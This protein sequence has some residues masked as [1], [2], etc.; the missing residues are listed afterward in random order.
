MVGWRRGCV[1][2]RPIGARSFFG[3]LIAVALPVGTGVSQAQ[4][5]RIGAWRAYAV[6]GPPR[7]QER[8]QYVSFSGHHGLQEDWL[9]N[10]SDIKKYVEEDASLLSQFQLRVVNL[11]LPLPGVLGTPLGKRIDDLVLY[12]LT[13]AGYNVASRANSHALDFGSEGLRY[14]DEKLENLNIRI[15]G[16]RKSPVFHWQVGK[17]RID[18]CAVARDL[19]QPDPDHLILTADT[20]DLALLKKE[21]EGADFRIAFAILGSASRYPSPHE[22]TQVRRLLDAGFDLVVCTGSHFIKGFLLEQGRPVAY[23]IGDHLHSLQ[24][25]LIDTEPL[26]M[27][28]VV[29]FADGQLA[30]I[31]VVPFHNDVRRG[32]LG[33]L[34]EAAFGEFVKTF[35]ERSVSDDAKYFSDE[36]VFQMMMRA[37]GNMNR[38][39]L[40]KLLRPRYFIYGAR[41]IIRQRPEW[42]V[43][44]GA[45]LVI[46]AVVLHRRRSSRRSTGDTGNA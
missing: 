1:R 9:P 2:A 30:Q 35:R 16:E 46:V 13:R 32:R 23:G 8:T 29:G 37:I 44:A 40:W 38:S 25:G 6:V 45:V 14:Y 43:A 7:L 11:G 18:I 17:S 28:L 15:I 36:S 21:T 24:Y 34:E 31:F 27:H 33:P 3:V 4:E 41:V 19:E 20:A 5:F 42:V 26:G 22:R 12:S 39:D 10:E